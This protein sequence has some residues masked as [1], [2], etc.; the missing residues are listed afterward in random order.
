MGIFDIIKNTDIFKPFSFQLS[1][2]LY[3]IAI[4]LFTLLLFLYIKE[5]YSYFILVLFLVYIFGFIFDILKKTYKND[6]NPKLKLFFSFLG[7]AP[8]FI[9]DKLNR[10]FTIAFQLF[11]ILSGYNENILSGIMILI[12][13]IL[14]CII[15]S[16]S[17]IP[18][19]NS[20]YSTSYG[21]ISL[22]SK[23]ISLSQYTVLS[24]YFTLNH[25][26]S[27][28]YHNCISF[29]FYI[30]SNTPKIDDVFSIF[31]YNSNNPNIAYIPKQ[32]KLVVLLGQDNLLFSKKDILLQ[33]WNHIVLNFNRG[34][35]DIFINNKLEKSLVNIIP[36]FTL[37]NITSGQN[38]GLIGQISNILF[39]KDA[40][41]IY[42]INSLYSNKP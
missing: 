21:G 16:K 23:P 10:F 31:N 15:G 4:F 19:F 40:I 6:Q 34:I 22:S 32:N 20:Y 27:K 18:F 33:K 1:I 29:W 36:N 35:L 37:D 8:C 38:N 12:E 17:N 39:F 7:Y 11:K 30:D 42:K 13:I 28:L 41:N 3:S 9:F 25:T 2:L 24:D 14:L 5:P 26:E